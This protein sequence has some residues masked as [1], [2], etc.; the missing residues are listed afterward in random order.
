M[1]IIIYDP[2]TEEWSGFIN[3]LDSNCRGEERDKAITAYIEKTGKEVSPTEF[4][5]NRHVYTDSFGEFR[6]RFIGEPNTP[7]EKLVRFIYSGSNYIN[8][9]R[10]FPEDF[11]ESRTDWDDMVN[12]A[13]EMACFIE[14]LM[15]DMA[16]E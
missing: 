9:K 5:K 2:H 8:M 10:K 15:E 1:K 14:E 16:K 13:D 11:T 12:Y 6:Y 7:L 3:S 4:L